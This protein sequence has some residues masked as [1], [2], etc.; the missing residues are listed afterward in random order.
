M[1]ST[2]FLGYPILCLPEEQYRQ[3]G[4]SITSFAILKIHYLHGIGFPTL[5]PLSNY[6]VLL[7][8]ITRT[9]YPMSTAQSLDPAHPIINGTYEVPVASHHVGK[10]IVD[11]IWNCFTSGKIR[12]GNYFLDR[13]QSL[14]R[15]HYPSLLPQD[16]RAIYMQLKMTIHAKES[17]EKANGSK[18]SLAKEYREVAK[19]L[20]VIVERASQRVT[21]NSLLAQL[22]AATDGRAPQPPI[23]TISTLSNPFS[24]SHE[25]SSLADVDVGNLNQMEMTVY[26][27]EAT[28][29]AAAV[30]DLQGQDASTQ[31]VV[32]TFSPE[33][34]VGNEVHLAGKS[35]SI[36]SGELYGDS[37]A[38]DDAGR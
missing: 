25:V 31:Q 12:G 27:S 26:E 34:I 10:R 21:H 9:Y 17:L 3:R 38:G 23:G 28:G 5:P 32:T 11:V 15:Q 18:R 8:Q 29:E 14:L 35:A 6:Q 16:R 37:E 20:F 30:I 7:A 2:G 24:D 19:Y 4:G 1:P 36:Y 22:S 33:V 13:S